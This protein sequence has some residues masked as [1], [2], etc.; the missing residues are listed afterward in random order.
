MAITV[1]NNK[2]ILKTDNTAW[3]LRTEEGYLEH[4]YYG[5]DVPDCDPDHLVNRQ[6][7]NFAPYDASL[8]LKYIYGGRLYLGL[9]RLL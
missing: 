7:L 6:I 3:I 9:L 4:L 5:A 1:R 8:G 2:F